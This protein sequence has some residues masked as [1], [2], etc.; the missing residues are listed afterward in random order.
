VARFLVASQ[1]RADEQRA[2]HPQTARRMR[3]W[4]ALGAAAWAV[5]ALCGREPFRGRAGAF[6]G[7]WAL[8]WLM[9]DW[10]IGMLESELG[11]PRN[12]GPADACTLA[13]VWL[14]PAAADA[15]RPWMTALAF[16][17][18]AL[19]GR[20]ARATAPTR[21]GR[22]LEGLADATFAIAALR[23]ARRQDWISRGAARAELARIALG[24]G[25][26]VLDAFGSRNGPD[27]AALR[28]ARPAAPIRAAALLAAGLGRR[29]LADRLLL[30]GTAWGGLATAAAVRR[31]ACSR[32]A[33]SRSCG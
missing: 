15:P 21:L 2:V 28:A 30:L 11:D 26:G 3:A 31:R 7:S 22:D 9:L 8:T 16:A 18:D 13:R 1:R 20:L 4:I 32:R 5:L 12:L 27:A 17:S 24:T 6:A 23:G 33:R 14:A 10:H 29:R 25:Y 19:D